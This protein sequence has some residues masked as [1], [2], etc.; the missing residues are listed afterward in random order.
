MP[1]SVSALQSHRCSVYRNPGTG[2]VVP[3]RFNQLIP[4]LSDY[5]PEHYSYFVYF[6]SRS[7][8]PARARACIDL[9]V[10]RLTNNREYVLSAK[11]LRGAS[12]SRPPG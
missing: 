3:W 5:M 6:G 11:E 7:S 12:R 9:A 4:V 10:K 2:R 1:D 8:Q